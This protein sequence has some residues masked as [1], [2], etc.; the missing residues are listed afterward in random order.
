MILWI[1]AARLL[2]VCEIL[3]A[4][5]LEWV[6]FPHPGDLPD[7]GM[8]P[9]SPVL[10]GGLFIPGPTRETLGTFTELHFREPC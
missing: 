6:P 2:S 8:E 10:S 1:V 4:R 7:P 3:Q 5:T 9:G